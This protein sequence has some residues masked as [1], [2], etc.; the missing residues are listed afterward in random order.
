MEGEYSVG[1]LMSEKSDTSLTIRRIR[2]V[3]ATRTPVDVGLASIFEWQKTFLEGS[4]V[5]QT[6]S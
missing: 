2:V 4:R 3:P 1:T 5:E 6:K